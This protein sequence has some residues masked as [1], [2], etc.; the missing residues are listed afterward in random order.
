MKTRTVRDSMG[1]LEVPAHALWGAQTQRAVDNF[2]ISGQRLPSRFIEALIH[3]KASAAEANAELKILPSKIAGAIE[4]AA[5]QL[6][7]SDFLEQFPIDVYQTGSG[8]ST[9]MNANEVLAELASRALQKP[10]HPNDHV[11]MGQSSNDTIPTAI[12]VSATLAVEN[13]LL[14]ALGS[15]RDTIVARGAAAG[16]TI[17]TGRTHL[18]DAMPIRIDQEMGAWAFQIEQDIERLQ[19]TLPRLRLLA[20]GGTAIGSGINCHPEFAAR[21]CKRLGARVNS[22]FQPSGNFFAALA[23]QETSA[24]LSGQL[25]VTATTLTKIAN[26]L[27]LMNSGPLAGLQEIA[28]PALQPGSSIMP[29]KINPV[30]PEAVTMVAARVAGNQ[31]TIA[32]AAQSG[33]FQLN[34]M[35]PVIAN[36]LLESIELLANSATALADKAIKGLTINDAVLTKTLASNPI[37]V[38]ALNAKIGYELGAEIAKIAY[39]EGRSVLDV[40]KE[41]TD[42][43]EDELQRLLDPRHLTGG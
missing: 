13:T 28:L 21:F 36:A 33:N 19:G 37:L 41:K 35:L 20:Q 10:V 6:L 9:N 16:D 11:N 25:Q 7:D 12:H 39:A 26:D 38:T 22:S 42:L 18:M 15:L 32:L 27:R 23:G 1:E 3:M 24:E 4:K 29:G 17:K 14:P 43:D 31:T 30:I 40:A 5:V 2:A 8:T 34:V